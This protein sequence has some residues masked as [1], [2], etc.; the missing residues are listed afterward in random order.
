M[1]IKSQNLTQKNR[2]HEPVKKKT[3]LTHADHALN[4]KTSL[5]KAINAKCWDCV[6]G[7]F[8]TDDNSGVRKEIRL[9]PVTK[10]SLWNFRPYKNKIA[11]KVSTLARAID[12][13]TETSEVIKS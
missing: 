4:N 7:K 5:R 3:L 6:G 10:C 1:M 12:S 9:C 13:F 2:H 11:R 8:S